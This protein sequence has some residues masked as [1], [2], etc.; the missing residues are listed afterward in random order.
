[1]ATFGRIVPSKIQ[2]KVT[3]FVYQK[4]KMAIID[5]KCITEPEG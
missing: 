1:M 2:H 3:I 5:E 4:Y